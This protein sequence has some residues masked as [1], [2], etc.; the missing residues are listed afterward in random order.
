ML[1][2]FLIRHASGHEPASHGGDESHSERDLSGENIVSRAVT[3]TI[4][5]S[6]SLIKRNGEVGRQGGGPGVALTNW[7]V[8]TWLYQILMS[9]A[10]GLIVGFAAQYALRFALRKYVPFIPSL[11]DYLLIIHRR[12]VDSE[13]Y[14]L[15]PTAIGVSPPTSLILFIPSL[16]TSCSF[17][18]SVSAA[19]LAPMT[20]WPVSS[21]ATP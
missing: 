11:T 5:A 1:A 12:W 19:S 4:T 3:T 7:L 8:E 17:G 14:L 10:I 2:T 20:S 6:A 16:L 9:V 21:P 18:S 13:S 15:Y